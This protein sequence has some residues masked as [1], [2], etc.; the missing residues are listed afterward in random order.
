MISGMPGG[1]DLRRAAD[2]LAARLPS[3]LAPLA[4]LA[5]N[6]RWSWTRGGEALFRDVDPHRWEICG[7]DPVR[8]L[9]EAP[10]LAL[11]RAAA[12]PELRRRAY[13][14]EECIA[15]ECGKP[16]VHPSIDPAHPV[17]FFCAEFGIHP[18]LPIYAGGLGVLAGDLLKA[19]SD[20]GTPLVAVGLLYHQGYFRQRIDVTGW[21]HEYWVDTDPLRLPAAV[22]TREGEPVTM[23]VPI[24]GRD[25]VAQ[26]WRVDVGRVPLY[27]LDTDL[28]ENQRVDRW[29]T[30][31]LYAGQADTRLA[32]YALLGL[33]GVRALRT[34]GI[35][36]SG[37]HLN[38]GH[39]ALATLE[40]AAGE[41]AAGRPLADALD[42]ARR[43][44]VFTTHTPVLAGNE[45]YPAEELVRAFSGLP[46]RLGTSWDEVL[47]LARRDGEQPGLTALGLRMSGATNAVSERHGSVARAMWRPLF[48]S[49]RDADVPIRHVTNGV[50]LFTWMAE[51]MQDLLDRHLGRGWEQ[52]CTDPETWE[53]IAE[54]PDVALWT[55]R[56]AL[57]A[58]LVDFVRDR[59]TLDRLARGEKPDYVEMASRAF[60]PERLTLGFA[61]R[62]ATYKRLN[63]LSHNL[64]RALRLLQG[65]HAVQILLS[66]K[67]HPMDDGAKGVVKLLFEARGAPHVGERIAYVHDYD[68]HV[69][70]FLVSGCDVWMNVPRPPLEASGTSGMK[71]AL[72]G[73]LN[74]SVLDGWWAEGYDGTNGWAI[75]GEVDPD[76]RAQD[77]RDSE[78]L[79]DLIEKQIVPLF[80]ERDEHGI[81]RGWLRMVKA[82]LRSVALRFT[83][84]RMV[85]DYASRAYLGR[86]TAS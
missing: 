80:Y 59:A 38:E 16:P 47:A 52:R 53:G 32:Q 8:L 25:V 39:A 51:P 21:Q 83:A 4:R 36:P 34:L 33:G 85:G 55:V 17:A 35:E 43:K 29:I 41:V 24:R 7:Q 42:A 68:M 5:F 70:K 56:C 20:S 26:I 76:E 13:S 6:Y 18:S 78:A 19:A 67:A 46:E 82:S 28:P 15:I 1:E 37:L 54:I 27:L 75:P 84:R 9:Q 77:E 3:G 71:A 48:A 81:P 45:T 2:Q 60:D 30:A 12:D 64:G 23:R 79:L 69:A 50:H 74:L 11:E 49:R 66:G 62:L 65:E 73:A 61:R 10:T 63:L 31:R 86:G 72:N 22:V 40:L 14:L 44:T 58:R 57:R